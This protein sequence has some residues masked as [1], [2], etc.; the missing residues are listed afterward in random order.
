MLAEAEKS[1]VFRH[2][3]RH[4]PG[5]VPQVAAGFEDLPFL[6]RQRALPWYGRTVEG[7]REFT[8]TGT[9]GRPKPVTWTPAED[10]W[11]VA[12][13][14]AF[15]DAW[16][17]GFGRAFISLGAGHNAGSASVVLGGLGLDVH[18]A[19]L[20]PLDQQC[21]AIIR[22]AP[23]VLYCSPSILANLI[24]GLQRRGER[25]TAVRRVITNGEILM[26]SARARALTFFGLGPSDLMDTYGSTEVGTIAHTCPSCGVYHFLPGVYPEAAP[27]GTVGGHPADGDAVP[28]ALSSVKRTSF[29]VIRLVTYDL[30]RGLRRSTCTGLARFSMDGIVGRCDDVLNYGELF[31]PYELADLIAG[32]LPAAR[33]FAFNPGNDV[34]IVVEGVEP[35]GFRDEM[36]R[37]Y[38]LHRRMT[39]LGLLNPPEIRFV[40][41]FDTFVRRSGLPRPGPGKDA[42]RVLRVAPEDSWFD[43][44]VR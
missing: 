13:K 31:S 27:S 4:F 29:P 28:L 41:D 43:G 36:W 22:S 39:D 1:T 37:R 3:R 7:A 30:V 38:P 9:S 10:R 24:M 40:R 25:P 16:L 21:A 8:S 6:D 5:V 34:T 2:A 32:L 14:Q 35:P 23:E 19:G 18:D 26:P 44:T 42:R 20:S 15:L 33:W 11:Y 12:E 17:T